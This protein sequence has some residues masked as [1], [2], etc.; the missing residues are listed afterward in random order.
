M[1]LHFRLLNGRNLFWGRVLYM[2]THQYQVEIKICYTISRKCCSLRFSMFSQLVKPVYKG[3]SREPEKCGLYEK[4]PFIYRLIL[5]ALF[6][7]E[8]SE[9]A[10]YRQWFVIQRW[11][12]RMVWLYFMNILFFGQN[13][14]FFNFEKWCL[15]WWP[16]VAEIMQNPDWFN[17]DYFN[18]DFEL[19]I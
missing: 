8:K 2:M 7:N 16:N 12:L 6:I 5:Y 10:L 18:G 13:V 1:Y 17:C 19:R 14:T 9:T 4:L 3:H 11:P 15:R